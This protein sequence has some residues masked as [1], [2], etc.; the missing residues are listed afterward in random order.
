MELQET[1]DS[2]E[3]YDQTKRNTINIIKSKLTAF[4]NEKL[5]DKFNLY[6][7]LFDQYKVFKSDS[8]YFYSLKTKEIA[9]QLNDSTLINKALLNLADIVIA[10]GMYKE[11]LDYLQKI[12]IN[13]VRDFDKPMFYGLYGR[14]YSDMAEYSGL[15]DFSQKYNELARYYRGKTLEHTEEQ[16]FFNSFMIAFNKYS[17]GNL[18]IAI[19]DFKLILNQNLKLG[20]LA[21]TYFILGEIFQKKE[22]N[23]LAEYYYTRAAIADIKN[24]T[25]E[26]LAIIRLSELLFKKNKLETASTLIQKAYADAQFYG[27]QQRKLQVGAILPLIEEEIVRNIEMERRRLYW[28]YV[29]VVI[30]LIITILFTSI[31]FRQFKRLQKARGAISKAHLQLKETHSQLIIVNEQLKS[32]NVEIE[33]VNNRLSEASKIK[34]EYLGFFFT[35]YDNIFEK[36]NEFTSEIEKNLS[37]EEY[38]KARYHLSRYDLKKEKEKLLHNF[39]TA[40]I[41]L[42]PDFINEFNSLMKP[43][44]QVALKEGQILNKELRIFALIRLG[45]KHNDKIAQI[46]GYSVNSIYAFK[47]KIRNMS[48]VQNENFDQ[49][50]IDNT[51]IKV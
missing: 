15:P 16:S 21:L 1:L 38:K 51:T 39:D 4:D 29:S 12:N 6:N 19:E 30:F 48:I 42:F 46:L 32:R 11:A 35:E 24:S 36:F 37:M 40:F 7:Q 22:Q 8:A 3:I 49:N 18:N 41:R 25:K 31:I 26:S 47:S 2:S 23:D 28:Q 44:S 20:E 43:M 50:L 33:K 27:A 45:V 5:V 14:C 34:E 10:V 17:A 13:F 9:V